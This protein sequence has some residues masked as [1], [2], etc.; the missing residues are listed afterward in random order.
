MSTCLSAVH[1]VLYNTAPVCLP[2]CLHYI[3]SC[4]TVIIMIVYLSV[5]STSG[6][7]Q[8]FTCMSTCLSAVHPVLYNCG[9]SSSPDAGLQGE[10]VLPAAR[11][12]LCHALV[13]V[14]QPIS[15]QRQALS[16]TATGKPAN[17]LPASGFVMP[18]YG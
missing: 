12:G 7:V 3:M 1:L 16:C 4:K 9:S 18:S 17:Q 8:Q 2:V 6:P 5:C 10:P 14:N 13:Q 11:V 15:F